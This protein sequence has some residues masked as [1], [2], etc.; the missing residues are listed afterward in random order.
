MMEYA[1]R[2][3]S[4]ASFPGYSFVS[5]GTEKVQRNLVRILSSVLVLIDSVELQ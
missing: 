4:Q 5:L 1:S 2:S 3:I